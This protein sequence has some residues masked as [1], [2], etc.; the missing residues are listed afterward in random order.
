[1][2]Y[3]PKFGRV[4]VK[5]EVV[6]EKTSGGVIIPDHIKEKHKNVSCVGEIVALGETAGWVDV[7]TEGL[8]QIMSVGDKV[9]F[10]RH[11]GAWLDATYGASGEN[12]DGTL[13]ICQ[14]E[15]ILAVIKERA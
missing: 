7:P 15:D 1:M 6:K 3:Q 8:K 2:E 10:G 11:S 9:A 13:F 14:D 12:D 4:I 5:R